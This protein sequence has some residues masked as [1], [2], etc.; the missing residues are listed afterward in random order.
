MVGVLD[1]L[2]LSGKAE[3]FIWWAEGEPDK[4]QSPIN[5]TH[6]RH[7]PSILFILS[8]ILKDREILNENHWFE[9]CTFNMVYWY[10]TFKKDQWCNSVLLINKLVPINRQI[11]YMKMT[12]YIQICYIYNDNKLIFL[13]L[14]D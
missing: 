14:Y 13:I 5:L 1:G 7:Q 3:E 2:S 11:L 9:D 8:R 4:F 6:P 12:L 10:H